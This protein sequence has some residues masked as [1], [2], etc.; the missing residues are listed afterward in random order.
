MGKHPVDRAGGCLAAIRESS[1]HLLLDIRISI[2]Y[3]LG[4]LPPSPV[5]NH[6]H[7]SLRVH[8]EFEQVLAQI[9]ALIKVILTPL[10]LLTYTQESNWQGWGD[11]LIVELLCSPKLMQSNAGQVR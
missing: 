11:A 10:R 3:E 7:V 8:A 9:H 1:P 5:P 2:M 4:L 6:G